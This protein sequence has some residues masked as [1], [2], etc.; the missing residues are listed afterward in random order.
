MTHVPWLMIPIA[1]ALL[2]VTRLISEI[3]FMLAEPLYR[4]L[5][6]WDPDG[7]FFLIS[8]HHLLQAGFAMLVILVMA[9]VLR[10]R[11]RD[12]GFNLRE[13]ERGIRLVAGACLVWFF[14]QGIA[15]ALMMSRGLTSAAFPFPLTIGNFAGYLAFQVLLS[16]TSEEI[17]FRALV[18]T[19]LIWYG[20]RAGLSE[21][22]AAWLAAG[23]A[24]VIFMLAHINIAFSPLRI[25]HL[26]MLQQLTVLIFGAFYAYL[27]IRT[28]SL[29]WPILAHNLLNGVIVIIGLVLFLAYGR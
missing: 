6:A 9:R 8:M 16:G 13:R 7:S 2:V 25:T 27:F 17:L 15:G 19:P 14:V 23:I 4:L 21:K 12:F 20:V 5:R 28:R 26:N 29:A 1:F 11:L 22:T 3:S 10:I 18:M 24:T